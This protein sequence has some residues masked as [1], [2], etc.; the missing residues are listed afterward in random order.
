MLWEIFT[1]YFFGS[2]VCEPYYTPDRAS[3]ASVHVAPP[4]PTLVDI[5]VVI[6]FYSKLP[7]R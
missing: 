6:Y 3:R 7:N 4:L 5:H 2:V 1:A